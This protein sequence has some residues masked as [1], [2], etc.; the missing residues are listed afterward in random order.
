MN[1]FQQPHNREILNRKV[2]QGLKENELTWPA[3]C[4]RNG[5]LERS[6]EMVSSSSLGYQSVFDTTADVVLWSCKLSHK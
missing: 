2:L 1:E 3:K 5:L 6:A 4:L